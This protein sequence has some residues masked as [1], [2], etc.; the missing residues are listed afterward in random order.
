MAEKPLIERLQGVFGASRQEVI[1]AA[2][3]LFGLILGTIV[4]IF[5]GGGEYHPSA[6]EIYAS[7]DSIAEIQKTSYIGTDIH[8]NPIGSLAAGDTLTDK[9]QMFPEA[10]K[11]ELPGSIININ[12]ASRSGLM[13]LPGVGEATANKIIEYRSK[14]HF[15]SIE[16]II[17]V[18]G[19]GEKKFEKMRPYITVGEAINAAS[20]ERINTDDNKRK[21]T[22]QENAN[23]STSKKINI[24]TAAKAEL[25]KLPGIGPATAQKIID[26]RRSA[27]FLSPADIKKV[28]GIGP[29]KYEKIA[30]FIVVK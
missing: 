16:D 4:K 19:I 11:K 29:K 23:K 9:E 27:L 25:E 2:V 24:N 22:K 1:A 7:L 15:K 6:D 5:G 30:P 17:K 21:K 10:R 28:K 20:T 8:G 3:I 13:K 26:Y 18:K 12:T 14:N